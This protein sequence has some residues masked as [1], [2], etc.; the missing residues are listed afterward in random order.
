MEWAR[1]DPVQ[2]VQK[3]LPHPEL[4]LSLSHLGDPRNALVLIFPI[5]FSGS[6]KL[7]FKV[8]RAMIMAEFINLILKWLIRGDRPYWTDS[9]LIQYP[10]TCETG[11]GTPSGHAMGSAS[12]FGTLA[13]QYPLS[14]DSPAHPPPGLTHSVVWIM[15]ACFMCLIATSRLYVACHYMYQV[16]GGA[17]CGLSVAIAN[18]RMD[19]FLRVISRHQ[20]LIAAVCMVAFGFATYYLLIA[21]GLDPAFSL[22]RAQA[23]CSN[24]AWVNVDTKP[25]Y[26][27]WR[28]AGAVVGLGVATS[29]LTHDN[30]KLYNSDSFNLQLAF[31]QIPRTLVAVCCLFLIEATSLGGVALELQYVFASFKFAV[32]PLIV[33]G[34]LGPSQFPSKLM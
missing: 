21:L 27:L 19:G 16:F 17:I 11:P 2:Y 20:H 30:S 33:C 15:Y 32:M 23:G 1:E 6:S 14:V 8:Y 26:V 7:G 18:S 10:I 13:L 34:L 12:V 22:L 31:K 29:W 28:D 25:F 9:T 3:N 5:V 4:M 24:P